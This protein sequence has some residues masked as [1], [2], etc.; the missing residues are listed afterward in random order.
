MM[1]KGISELMLSDQIIEGLTGV[2]FLDGYVVLKQCTDDLPPKEAEEWQ[3]R[4]RKSLKERLEEIRR[5][6]KTQ[7]GEADERNEKTNERLVP[8][9]EK[10]NEEEE[11][12]AY[13]PPVPK[14]VCKVCQK[15]KPYGREVRP[16][17]ANINMCT[18]SIEE[19]ENP[20]EQQNSEDELAKELSEQLEDIIKKK[21]T[22]IKEGPLEIKNRM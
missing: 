12:E 2:K 7:S 11:E 18:C 20:R 1:R 4:G 9:E 21:V 13:T 22:E 19:E 6:L 14:E 8:L 3:S 5:R 10:E 17:E 15:M 16:D